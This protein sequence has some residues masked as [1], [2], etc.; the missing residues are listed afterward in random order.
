MITIGYSTRKS[1]E[2]FKAHIRKTIGLSE[3]KYEIIELVND[4]EFGLSEA[5]NKILNSPY[6]DGYNL[7]ELIDEYGEFYIIHP[8][9][10]NIKRNLLTGK[11]IRKKSYESDIYIDTNYIISLKIYKYLKTCFS[12]TLFINHQIIADDSDIFYKNNINP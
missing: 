7:R 2:D 1:N 11:I 9:E 8:D 12:H 6:E 5:Y 3:S 4:G 10:N